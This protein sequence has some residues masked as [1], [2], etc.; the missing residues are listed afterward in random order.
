MIAASKTISKTLMNAALDRDEPKTVS[1]VRNIYHGA[2]DQQEYIRRVEVAKDVL[3]HRDT[4]RVEIV[5]YDGTRLVGHV[6][7]ADRPKRVL[8]A[9]HGWR[10]NWS[11]DF[12]LVADTWYDE[13]CTVLYAEQRAQGESGGDYMGFGLT[14]RFDCAEW[15]RWAESE[16]AEGLPVYLAGISMGASTVL[17]TSGLD[18]PDC[19][20]GIIA[21]CGFTSPAAI[22]EHVTRDNLHLPYRW[23]Q[24]DIDQLCR[25]KLNLG[26]DSYSTTEAMKA[27]TRPVLFIHGTEDELVPIAMTY[28]N[29]AVCRAPKRL[30]TVEG[31]GHGMSFGV[32]KE[33]YVK[34][35]EAFWSDYDE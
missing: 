10:S 23:H 35:L 21:D 5:S 11:R 12:G 2:V 18:L 8:I 29:Y 15:A 1:D 17:M 7:R 30:F 9:M 25:E 26:S 31:A 6:Y 33:G 27:N 24:K 4:E 22:W 19:V 20:H 32:D 16:L 13:G 3:E 28:E 34:A 14:E